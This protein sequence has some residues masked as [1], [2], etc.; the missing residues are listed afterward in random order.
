VPAVT[1][2]EPSPPPPTPVPVLPAEKEAAKSSA[3]EK[4]RPK[5]TLNLGNLFK[6]AAPPEGSE[7]KNGAHPKPDEPVTEEQVLQAWNEFAEQ[8]KSQVAEYHLLTQA[9]SL[10]GSTITLTI[11]NPV[12]EPLLQM[13]KPELIAFLRTRLN[14]S[15][16][17]VA[18]VMQPNEIK[19]KPYSSKEKLDYL[20]EKNPLIKDLQQKLGLDLRD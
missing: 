5:T 18:G 13:V 10:Q 6:Q 12:E 16:I 14:N 2:N 1:V 8:R 17:Q 15:S 19:R 20:V 11:T 9:I 7:E 3:A 4:H